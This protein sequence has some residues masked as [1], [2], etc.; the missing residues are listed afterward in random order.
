MKSSNEEP[1]PKKQRTS[2]PPPPSSTKP[3]FTPTGTRTASPSP[4]TPSTQVAK[5]TSAGSRADYTCYTIRD[6]S[7]HV[8]AVVLETKMDHSSQ[9][10]LAQVTPQP[11]T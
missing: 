6:S 8:L 3:P 11:F 7:E 4:T 2:S 5:V 1:L 10:A 9:D